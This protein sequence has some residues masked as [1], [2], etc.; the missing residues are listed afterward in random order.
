MKFA[1]PLVAAAALAGGAVSAPAHRDPCHLQHA[2]PSD[3]HT[4]PWRGL[5]CTSYADERLAADR[6]TVV[7]EGRVYWCHR[8]AALRAP[9]AV[10]ASARLTPG[11][12][13]PRVWQWTIH[14]TICVPGWTARVRPPADY[15]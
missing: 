9:A 15:T 13:N 6:R 2:C 14:R 3:R 11:A 7:Y 4:Y 10:L 5:L 1:L 12:R 8:E